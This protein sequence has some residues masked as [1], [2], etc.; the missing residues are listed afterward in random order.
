MWTAPAA[1]ADRAEKRRSRGSH[2]QTVTY[3]NFIAHPFEALDELCGGSCALGQLLQVV[4]QLRLKQKRRG[5]K[6]RNGQ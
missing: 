6:E 2:S 5:V 1:K 3:V 4:G